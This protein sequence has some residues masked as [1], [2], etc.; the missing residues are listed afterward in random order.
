MPEFGVPGPWSV[1]VSEGGGGRLIKVGVFISKGA[2]QVANFMGRNP[3]S[4]LLMPAGLGLERKAYPKEG[5]TCEGGGM[6]AQLA[7]SLS[8]VGCA[9]AYATLLWH[10]GGSNVGGRPACI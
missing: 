5:S 2:Q 6:F 8:N 9:L 10:Q 1:G 3:R 4:R 7:V